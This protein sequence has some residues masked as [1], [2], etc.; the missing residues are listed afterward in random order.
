[1]KNLIWNVHFELCNYIQSSSH[2]SYSTRI[3]LWTQI[4]CS[5]YL[6]H[7]LVTSLDKSLQSRTSNVSKSFEM[8]PK[9]SMTK[10]SDQGLQMCL[11]CFKY[12]QKLLCAT[13]YVFISISHLFLYYTTYCWVWPGVSHK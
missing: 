9:A 8:C 11:N 3:L 6:F 12:V 13:L 5:S 1:M 10:A 2:L 4:A 7:H